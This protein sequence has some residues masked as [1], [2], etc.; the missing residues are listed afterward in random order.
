MAKAKTAAKQLLNGKVIYRFSRGSLV[1]FSEKFCGAFFC[2]TTNFTDHDDALSL[3][4][5]EN[6]TLIMFV[7]SLRRRV[8]V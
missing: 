7:R 4:V 1:M 5:L 2:F 8:Q 6:R 3:W